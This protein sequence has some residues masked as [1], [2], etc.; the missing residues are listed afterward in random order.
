[1]RIISRHTGGFL[2]RTRNPASTAAPTTLAT[3]GGSSRTLCRTPALPLT[4]SNASSDVIVAPLI[5]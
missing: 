5:R 1:M 3:G 2:P 4:M